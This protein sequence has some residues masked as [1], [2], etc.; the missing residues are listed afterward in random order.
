MRR[1]QVATLL[2]LLAALA[3]PP[4]ASAA[5]GTTPTLYKVGVA[6]SQSVH[7]HFGGDVEVG[8]CGD[9]VPVLL[10]GAGSGQL[11]F[12]FTGTKPG[13]AVA[14]PFSPS[15]FGFD[16]KSKAK[17]TMT[18]SLTLT[19]GRTCAGF[20]PPADVTATTSACGPQTFGLT[21]NGQWKSGFLRVWGEEDVLF[22]ATPGRQ[23]SGDCP[24]PL[25]ALSQLAV[26]SSGTTCETKSGAPL[27]L[28]TNELAAAGRGLANVRFAT[29]PKALLHPKGRV[30]TFSRKVVK[31]CDIALSN[32]AAPLV[33][34]VTTRLTLTL[35]RQG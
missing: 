32:S 27:W 9:N 6:G 30:T 20:E 21:V 25:L 19:N 3:A 13:F 17:G 23:A 31:S 35:R 10:T 22:P 4:V 2:T 34:D 33:V 28:R 16:V 12:R 7:W 5:G 29:T 8:A 15:S 18:G 1:A 24:F 11:S 14:S 26:K